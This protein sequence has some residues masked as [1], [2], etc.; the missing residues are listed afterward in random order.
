MLALQRLGSATD[1]TML[2]N[3]VVGSFQ[4]ELS[5]EPSY[6]SAWCQKNVRLEWSCTSGPARTHVI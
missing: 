3:V 5:L 2:I 6:K 4:H 1:V